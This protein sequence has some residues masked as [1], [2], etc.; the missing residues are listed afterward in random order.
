MTSHDFQK[1]SPGTELPLHSLPA[2][3]SEVTVDRVRAADWVVPLS[4]LLDLNDPKAQESDLQDKE[5][6]I[7]IYLFLIK[8]PQ[9]GTYLIDSGVSENFLPGKNPPISSLVASQMN[10]EKLKVFET[11]HKALEKRKITPRGIF[12]THLHLD[13]VMGASE[14]SRNIPFYVGP[15]EVDSKKFINVFVQGSTNRLL[16]ENPQLQELQF[17]RSSGSLSVL[18]FLGDSS[19]FVISVPGHTKGSLAFFIPGNKESHLILGDTC[20][21]Q[22][23][24]I[25]SVPPGSFTEDLD[26]NRENLLRL[27]QFS[28]DRKNLFIYPGHQEVLQNNSQDKPLLRQG[29]R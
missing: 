11:T 26:Q 27:K 16:G 14:L 24:W 8:H 10:L 21:T 28:Q 22:W 19:F 6:P 25:H 12:F 15:K 5:E 29:F 7:S 3:S 20:H 1:V 4:G 9:Y 2:K 18:D 13:H 17:S 23:G